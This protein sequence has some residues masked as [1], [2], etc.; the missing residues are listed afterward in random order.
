MCR[1]HPHDT[2]T[3]R[4]PEKHRL[5]VG[6]RHQHIALGGERE[7]VNVIVMADKRGRVGAAAG[8]VPEADAFVVRGGGEGTGIRGPGQG[9][10]AGE[11]AFVGVQEG[12]GG[13][14]PEFEGCICGWT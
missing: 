3:P 9:A 14:G 8:Y 7:A 12:E 13:G 6:T 1:Q 4:V 2:P 11:V 10:Q 5:V